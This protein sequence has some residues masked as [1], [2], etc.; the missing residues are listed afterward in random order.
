[1]FDSL[2]S[3]GAQSS[4]FEVC[5]ITFMA[6]V[7]GSFSSA[8][9]YRVPMGLSWFRTAQTA[10]PDY[11]LEKQSCN[12]RRS[13]CTSCGHVL[14]WRDLIP[15][16]SWLFMHGRCRYCKAPVS[17]V[18]PAAELAT[19]LGCLGVYIVFDLTMYSLAYFAL[20]PFL[21][22]LLFIDLK[23]MILPN[24]LVAIAAGFG[25]VR[26]LVLIF[27]AWESVS[28]VF[29]QYFG[30]ALGFGGFAWALGFLMEKILKKEALGFGDVK[31]FAMAGLWLG[32]AVLPY[33]LILSGALGIGIAL[34]WRVV[35]KE[36]VF[37][38]GPALI[39]AF[40]ILLLIE[41][42]HFL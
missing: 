12:G 29:V 3:V 30:A 35:Y 38:F 20:I 28:D 13:Q 14:G 10:K 2:V 42:S 23:H 39:L 33:F 24:Q 34:L 1:M 41:G 15:V 11:K 25:I 9:I 4:V 32:G 37:P 36:E 5:I 7:L 31:F 22:A 16:L 27:Y 8:L 17:S 40:Y 18:Y 26:I 6:L 19:L 21:V